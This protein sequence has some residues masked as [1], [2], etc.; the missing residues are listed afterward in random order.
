MANAQAGI[1]VE[2]SSI[3]RFYELDFA[4]PPA[5]S[6]MASLHATLQPHAQ[7]GVASVLACSTALWQQW[8]GAGVTPLQFAPLES[9][10]GTYAAPATPGDL[11][12]W[13]HG[14]DR[15]ALA[16][17]QLSLHARL[18]AFGAHVTACDGF[19]YRD[20][21]DLTGFVDGSANPK[22]DARH[23]VALVADGPAAGGSYV[24]TQR[25]QH[26]LASFNALS[27]AAQEQVIGRTKADSIEL[28]G[29]AMPPDSH[30]SRTDIKHDG[31]AQK[32]YRRSTPTIA[33]DSE[34]LYFLA[35]SAEA[36][37]FDRLLASMYG[38]AGP[39]QDSLLAYSQPRSGAYWFAPAQ[40]QLEAL[41]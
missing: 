29:D 23:E 15:A 4:Q 39:V 32:I 21:R 5:A 25:W 41:E 7:Q 28:T 1:F 17:A 34:G 8:G 6:A 2:G 10:C 33:A 3:H 31:V 38:M 30:V 19:V 26:D 20:S 37:R 12:I 27:V 16:D 13:L 11:F 14:N 24:M 18:R 9:A 22:E 36:A 35:F 40:S